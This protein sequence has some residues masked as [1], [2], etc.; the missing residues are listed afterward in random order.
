MKKTLFIILN[1]FIAQLLICQRNMA[2]ESVTDPFCRMI[3]TIYSLDALIFRSQNKMKQ[4][5][6]TDTITSNAIVIVKKKGTTISF[7]Q[8]IPEEGNQ[9]L[10]FC[11][12]SAWEIDHKNKKMNCIGTNTEDL[13][14]NS[15]SKFFSFTL[16]NVDTLISRMKPFWRIIEQTKEQTVISLDIANSSKD[17][18]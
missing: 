3:K 15:M 17:L 4:V 8:I 6:E 2:Q 13:T 14:Y 11:N 16:F 9:E 5:F 10:L 1:V 7:L 18:S 12:D